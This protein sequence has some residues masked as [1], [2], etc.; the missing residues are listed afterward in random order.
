MR[1]NM[2]AS[3][4]LACLAFALGPAVVLAKTESCLFQGSWYGTNA[5]GI[6]WMSMAHGQSASSG[7]YVLQTI[8]FDVTLGGIWP[9]AVSATPLR[10]SWERV[11][12]RTFAVTVIGFVLDADEKPVWIA[13][14]SGYDTLTGDC[15]TMLIGGGLGLQVFA[16]TSN[17]FEDEPLF[18]IP[19]QP[20]QGYR[21]NAAVD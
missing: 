9:T 2:I 10:G 12:D 8:G 18:I 16:A 6:Y 17:P 19:L 1:K 15:N 4:I 13:K 3:L 11:D 21:M 5:S 20:H 14:M 7:T